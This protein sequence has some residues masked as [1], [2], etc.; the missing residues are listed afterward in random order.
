MRRA[1]RTPP[2]A[3][4]LLIGVRTEGSGKVRKC[5]GIRSYHLLVVAEDSYIYIYI[6]LHSYT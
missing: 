3:A 5:T 2:T 1:D 4:K 6:D